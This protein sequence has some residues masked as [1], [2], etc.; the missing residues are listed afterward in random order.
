MAIAPGES[1]AA[2]ASFLALGRALRRADGF[3]LLVAVCNEPARQARLLD[4][5]DELLP[6]PA[7]R[8][9]VPAECIDVLPLVQASLADGP[10]PPA[11]MVAGLGS[12]IRSAA[13]SHERLRSLN[14]RREEWRECVPAPVVFWLPEYLLQPLAQQAP[15]FL[16]WRSG[17]F[18]FLAPL[19]RVVDSLAAA[20]S[21]TPEVWRLS[22]SECRQRMAQLRD[23]LAAPPPPRDG[24]PDPAAIRWRLELAGHH[25]RLGE[26]DD[27]LRLARE[28]LAMVPPDDQRDRAF[29]WDLIADVLQVRGEFDEAL[30]ILREEVLPVFERLGDVRGGVVSQANLALIL[31]SRNAPGDREEAAAL[32]RRAHDAAERM[33]IPEA[34][35]I[36]AV[37]QEHRLPT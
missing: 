30:D 19:G 26:L 23:W 25:R 12:G 5:L 11:V 16:D 24:R 13:P 3:T 35:H 22:A 37:Q 6:T 31:L 9:A 21:Y 28:V 7:L 15:D 20:A 18:L 10:A 33:R 2:E 32:L 36:R 14:H 29:A 34:A 17:T 4:R 8:V 27:C 1:E